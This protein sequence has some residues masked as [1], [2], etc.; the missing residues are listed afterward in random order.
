MKHALYIAWVLALIGV[1]ISLYFGEVMKWPLCP[2]CWYQRI[3]LF[4]LAILLGVA[5]YRNDPAFSFYAL[6]LA[7][8]GE[9]FALYQIAQRYFPILRTSAICGY[10]KECSEVAF[11]LFGF[12]TLPVLSALGFLS[13]G[14]FLYIAFSKR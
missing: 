9:L 5:S 4:P 3:A 1:G 14:T 10:A 8:A 11:E 6:W 12:L 13:I 2:L 7:A